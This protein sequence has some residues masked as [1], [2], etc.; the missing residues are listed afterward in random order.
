MTDVNDALRC[1]T[2]LSEAAEAYM[3]A[4]IDAVS[5][6]V[7]DEFDAARA[8]ATV[9]LERVALYG[10]GTGTG[11]EERTARPRC[12]TCGDLGFVVVEDEDGDD[13]DIE[14]HDCPAVSQ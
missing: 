10:T 6:E 4:P 7:I 12:R 14:C 13:N 3:E 9:L 1:L 8:A 5:T 11:T 2:R